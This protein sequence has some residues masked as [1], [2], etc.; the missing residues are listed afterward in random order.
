V[1]CAIP[2]PVLVAEVRR[3]AWGAELEVDGEKEE[4]WVVLLVV[5]EVRG[6]EER[7]W[8]WC[9]CSWVDRGIFLNRRM[10]VQPL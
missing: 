5:V 3:G 10:N 7:V 4:R 2:I 6:E 9:C 8:W 1:W